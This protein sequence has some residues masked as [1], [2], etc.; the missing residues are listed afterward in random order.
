M[1]KIEEAGQIAAL[2]APPPHRRAVLLAEA[3]LWYDAAAA[4][5][6]AT[7][8]DRHAALDA[9]LNEVGLV[10][11][12]R[13]GRES[14]VSKISLS[15]DGSKTVPSLAGRGETRRERDREAQRVH[16]NQ[17]AILFDEGPAAVIK[18]GLRALLHWQGRKTQWCHP[19]V[20]RLIASKL[21]ALRSAL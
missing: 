15:C 10:E 7:A 4:A 19:L 3:G 11:P 14:A 21:Y 9:L 17:R 18:L 2:Q 8:S 13:Y 5:T 20:A 6:E 12:A 16:R 1:I